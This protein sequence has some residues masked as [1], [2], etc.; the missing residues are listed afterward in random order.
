M[1]SVLV[2]DDDRLMVRTLCD[3]LRRR[4]FDP[5]GVHSGEDALARSQARRWDAVVMDVR[6]GGMTGVEA[7]RLLR[8]LQPGVPVILMTA[9][10]APEL[11]TEATRAG[12]DRVLAKPFPPGVLLDALQLAVS[13]SSPV[14]LVDDD[15][16]F[17][18][19]LSGVLGARGIRT[20]QA[21]GLEQA[22]LLLRAH[23]PQTVLLDLKL[24]GGDPRS[25]VVAIR[26]AVPDVRLILF[27]GHPELL[28]ST[29]SR[30]P[31][32]WFRAALGKPLPPERLFELLDEHAGG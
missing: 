26:Q 6:M 28:A 31:G 4:G 23:A 27:S 11:L 9:Y 12:V 3:L 29:T 21:T 15:A 14:L 18:R 8:Q 2:V 1:R 16:E 24:D 5:H 22:L 30:L 25:A 10:S 32:D 7:L 13:G 20:L 17:L 19:T